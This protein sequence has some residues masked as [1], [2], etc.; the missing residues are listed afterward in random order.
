M[1]DRPNI[2]Y[3]FTDQQS[4]SAMSGAG[5]PDLAT[6]A[7][8]GLAREGVLFENAYCTQPLCTPC[9][10]SMFT[11]MMPHECGAPRNGMSVREDLRPRE[12]GRVLQANGHDCVYGGKWHIPYT[13]MPQENNHGFRVICG[14]N[15]N[16]LAASCVEYFRRHADQDPRERK[17]FFLVASF[18]N[19]HNICE[20]GRNMVLPWGS[21][22]D[23]PPT[24]ECPNLPPNFAPSPFE[25]EIVRIEQLCH[26]A[27]YPYS[28]RPPED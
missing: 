4:A 6:P 25:P 26:W 5:N 15:D 18:D 24:E 10:A 1:T 8:D 21:I 7:M 13:A 12:L 19:P 9:R 28:N 2:L 17:P 27:I 20:W 22:G 23:P 11:G 16:E 14:F 3:I